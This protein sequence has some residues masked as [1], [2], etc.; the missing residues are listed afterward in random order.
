VGAAC[1]KYHKLPLNTWGLYLSIEEDKGRIL[2][3]F[4]VWPQQDVRVVLLT[5]GSHILG[6]GDLSTGGVR[7][8]RQGVCAS[9]GRVLSAPCADGHQ[10]G[11]GPDPHGR[12]RH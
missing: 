8:G 12:S 10:R 1:Q 3:R 5:D 4:R 2:E 9:T 6:L 7:C 11:Q